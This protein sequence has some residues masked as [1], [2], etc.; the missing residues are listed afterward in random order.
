MG[1]VAL[2]VVSHSARLAEGLVELAAQMAADVRI[3]AAGGTDDGRIGT[4]FD[5]VEA[6]VTDLVADDDVTGVVLVADLG[7]AAMTIDSVLELHDD[8]PVLHA[9]GPLVEGIVA[10]AVAAQTGGTPREV[11]DAVAAAG[12]GF[13]DAGT[14]PEGEAEAPPEGDAGAPGGGDVVG[15][16]DGTDGQSVRDTVVI[17]DP[18]GLHARPAAAVATTAAGFD[19]A[20]TVDGVDARSVLALMAR[21]ITGGSEITVEA[22]GG[23]AQQAVTEVVRT[24]AAAKG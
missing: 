14:P 15:R 11:A 22:S 10:A 2:V 9:D 3:V 6:A 5:A 4:S 18:M 7:S 20:V 21:N 13:A 16:G 24:I 8:E 12:R 23:D 19:S 17:E 1:R